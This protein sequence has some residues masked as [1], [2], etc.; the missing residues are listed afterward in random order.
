VR[1]RSTDVYLYSNNI[2]SSIV[3]AIPAGGAQV[4]AVDYNNGRYETTYGGVTGWFSNIG[5][6]PSDL[7]IGSPPITHYPANTEPPV[8][9]GL[10]LAHGPFT[11][12][13]GAHSAPNCGGANS[14]YAI[15]AHTTV[16][17]YGPPSG[18]YYKVHAWRASFT[19]NDFVD[20][21]YVPT[22]MFGP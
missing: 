6:I 1:T 17:T 9:T 20:Y 8:V 15:D 7:L 4:A 13:C 21:G 22:S 10:T 14:F 11:P 16:Y 2:S 12:I 19:G 5:M 18:G 3:G